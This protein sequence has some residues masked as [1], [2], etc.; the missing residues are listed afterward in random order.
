MN[1][2]KQIQCIWKS[3]DLD[4]EGITEHVLYLFRDDCNL[5]FDVRRHTTSLGK[6]LKPAYMKRAIER[7]QTIYINYELKH[8]QNNTQE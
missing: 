5:P 2:R 1:Q 4:D 8:E 6:R 3:Y 7:L